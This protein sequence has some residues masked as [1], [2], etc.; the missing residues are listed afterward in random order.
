MQRTSILLGVI[1]RGR[2]CVIKA[3]LLDAETSYAPLLPVLGGTPITASLGG[4]H[5]L[6]LAT[7][8]D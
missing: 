6:L 4:G 5:D 1:G 7:P 3:L 2:G 8:T